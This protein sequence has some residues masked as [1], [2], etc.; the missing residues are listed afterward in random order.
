M[1]FVGPNQGAMACGEFGF[2]RMAEPD[3]IFRRDPGACLIRETGLSGALGRKKI[4]ITAGPTH[5]PIDPVRYHRQPLVRQAGLCHRPGGPR[6]GGRRSCSF[7]A[8]SIFPR[9]RACV[10]LRVETARDMAAAVEDALPCD[11]FIA[12]AAVA[13]WRVAGDHAEKIK[14]GGERPARAETGRKSRHSGDSVAAGP[15]AGRPRRRLCRRNRKARRACA[16]KTGAQGL[17]P[18]RRQ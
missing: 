18:D 7:P 2:G 1:K 13:D 11:I 3:E 12:A 14:K 4:V 5:E 17:R 16:R 9:P 6:G 15:E 10:Y 8:R